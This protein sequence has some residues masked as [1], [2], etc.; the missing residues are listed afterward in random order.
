MF[1]GDRVKNKNM[2]RILIC[3]IGLIII[4][5]MSLV[6]M[7]IYHRMIED[8]ETIVWEMT[9]KSAAAL[10]CQYTDISEGAVHVAKRAEEYDNL[11]E[12]MSTLENFRQD[13]GIYR[14]IVDGGERK[15][16]LADS[17][18]MTQEKLSQIIQ[19]CSRDGQF[20]NAYRGDT[21][22]YHIV[23]RYPYK[24]KTEMGYLY[25]E[26]MIENVYSDSFMQF[27]SGQGYSYLVSGSTGQFL[28]FPNNRQGQGLYGDLFQM[29]QESPE[30]S[31]DIISQ[32]KQLMRDK[33]S[34]TV[35]M[36]F[37][38]KDQYFCFTPIIEGTDCYIVSIIPSSIT[39][40]NGTISIAVILLMTGLVMSGVITIFWLDQI[41]RKNL[42][43]IQAADYAN[44]AKSDFLSNMSHEIR[45]PMNGITGMTQLALMNQNDPER[46]KDCLEKIK[47]SSSYMLTLINDILDVS[48][49]ES[50]KMVLT[51]NVFSLTKLAEEIR[52]FLQA[53]IE[54]RQHNFRTIIPKDSRDWVRG[55]LNRIRQIIVNLVSNAIKYTP[56]KGNIEL[57]LANRPQKE[58]TQLEIRVKDNGIGMGEEYQ[59]I[60]FEPFSQEHTIHSNGTG[61]GMAITDSLTR[62]MNGTIQVE[63]KK[64]VG[65]TF[66]VVLNLQ[67][68][69]EED[70]EKA[71]EQTGISKQKRA[72]KSKEELLNGI[73]V[74]LTEDNALNAEIASELLKIYGATIEWA[75]DGETAVESFLQAEPYTYDLI[76]MDIQM[77]GINGYEASRRIRSSGKA[78]AGIIPI[79]AMTANTFTSDIQKSLESGMNAH[80]GKPIE[81]EALV[82]IILEQCHR[83]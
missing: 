71:E 75:K 13:Y 18:E 70:I 80:L 10:E 39:Q 46:V 64:N 36:N 63:S 57:Y 12:Y 22:R 73:S 41:R 56:E 48:K 25:A 34:G 66:T 82:D 15:E 78:D 72:G 68:A 21:G 17:K 42:L 65:S 45:T 44:R 20:S 29:L 9:E 81:A 49:I 32:M 59:K 1:M 4:G 74:L 69:S 5:S 50:G 26:S 6:C 54:K 33:Q 58:T 83:G 61:L 27:Y 30:N 14:V 43:Q 7:N 62:L 55:N 40:R 52:I 76:L 53:Q 2:F 38:N 3:F 16:V 51:E 11:Q 79:V 77:P 37:R 60:L 47:I 28:L 35:Q 19:R 23:I 31:K 24:T 67:K 8:S